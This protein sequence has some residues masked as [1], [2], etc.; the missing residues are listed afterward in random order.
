LTTDSDRRA[1]AVAPLVDALVK[2]GALGEKTGKDSTER[3]KGACGETEIWTLDPATMEYR[4][5]QSARIASIEAGKSIRRSGERVRMLFNAKD[6]AG[7]FLRRHAGA[8][9][10]LHR[11]R[12]P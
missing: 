1:F 7:E 2:K 4:P 6:K 3:R 11:P 8:D 9:A 5:K 12:H 10:R